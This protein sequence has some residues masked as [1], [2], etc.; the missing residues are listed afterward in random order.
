MCGIHFFSLFHS[1]LLSNSIIPSTPKFRNP[2][3]GLSPAL[4]PSWQ[5]KCTNTN[6]SRV[7]PMSK[8]FSISLLVLE[9]LPASL[10]KHQGLPRRLLPLPHSTFCRSHCLAFFLPHISVEQI[11][12]LLHEG[13]R[14]SAQGNHIP[15]ALRNSAMWTPLTR[16]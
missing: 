5:D 16:S 10:T 14:V 3:S 9:E 11:S 8:D 2:H 4:I 1:G 12:D 7:T 13:T 15:S 6:Q